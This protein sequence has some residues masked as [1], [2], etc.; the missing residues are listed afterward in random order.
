MI[1]PNARQRTAQSLCSKVVSHIYLFLKSEFV[2]LRAESSACVRSFGRSFGKAPNQAPGCQRKLRA[3][4][5]VLKQIASFKRITSRKRGGGNRPLVAIRV[6]MQFCH[7]HGHQVIHNMVFIATTLFISEQIT[8]KK[9]HFRSICMK[10]GTFAS[11][12]RKHQEAPNPPFF[13][14]LQ[15]SIQRII[16][17][18]TIRHSYPHLTPSKYATCTL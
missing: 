7:R 3:A 12:S 5:P 14:D 1:L 9:L 17:P 4:S 18:V 13:V 10:F 2:F 16:T 11:T 15:T 8:Y 6:P